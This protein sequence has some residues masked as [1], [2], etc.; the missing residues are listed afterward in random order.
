MPMDD[1]ADDDPDAPDVEL[2]E[3][4]EVVEPV[5]NFVGK[6]PLA[7]GDASAAIAAGGTLSLGT[8]T[9]A[10]EPSSSSEDSELA[11]EGVRERDGGDSASCS[12]RNTR[13]PCMD[14]L[15]AHSCE[16]SDKSSCRRPYIS[17]RNIASW[18]SMVLDA[19]LQLVLVGV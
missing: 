10:Y 6:P 4:C 14:S 1:A 3:A 8:A 9:G 7:A 17:R 18:L 2:V 13:N 12:C 11:S 19:L 15:R 5:A 16:S